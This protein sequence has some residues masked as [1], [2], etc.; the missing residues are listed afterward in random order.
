MSALLPK[1]D[2]RRREWNADCPDRQTA[3]IFWLHQSN[4][5][6]LSESG[7]GLAMDD[8]LE[9]RALI[10]RQLFDGASD[11]VFALFGCPHSVHESE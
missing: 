5:S 10:E 4:Y 7:K 1:E 6:C 3:A 8:V 9:I 2:I 11:A